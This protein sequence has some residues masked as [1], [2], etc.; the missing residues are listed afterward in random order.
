MDK[1]GNGCAS[2]VFFLHVTVKMSLW[3]SVQSWFSRSYTGQ[4]YIEN[5]LTTVGKKDPVSEYFQNSLEL[6]H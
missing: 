6:W 2:F 5:S 3:A 1:S 4:W